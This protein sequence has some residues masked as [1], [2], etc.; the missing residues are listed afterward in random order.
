MDFVLYSN[1]ARLVDSLIAGHVDIAWN[2]N[3]A[4]V[5]TVLQTDGQCTALAQ[6]DTDVDYTTVFVA[7]A[8][9]GLRFV[10]DVLHLHQARQLV[11]VPE[12]A[13]R[14]EGIVV[15]LDLARWRK[16]FASLGFDEPSPGVLEIVIPKRAQATPRSSS[17][18]RLRSPA[19][20]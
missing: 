15:T 3:L 16:D 9:S 19:A 1:Y 14:R 20:R 8:G 13:R 18:S 5:R 2:T 7:R 4:Y 11:A 17:R 12:R 10:G 6:R